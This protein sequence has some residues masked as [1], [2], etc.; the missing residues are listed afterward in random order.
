MQAL[1]T[2]KADDFYISGSSPLGVPFNNLRG[3]SAERARVERIEKGRPGAPCT[4]K[5]LV[6][7]TEFGEAPICTAS[8][9]YQHHKIKELDNLALDNEEYHERL[10]KITEK[11]CLCEGLATAAY[12]KYEILEKKEPTVVAICPGPNTAYFNKVYSLQEMVDHIY[13]RTNIL[14]TTQRPHMFINELNLYVDHLKKYIVENRKEWSDKN[15]KFANRFEEELNKGIAYYED[16]AD[17][18]FTNSADKERFLK[19][20]QFAKANMP[21]EEYA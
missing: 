17:K 4:K 19:Q 18:L 10:A 11:T 3:C 9:V 12:L 14:N 15:T 7:S 21:S 5:Y 16:L 6:M 2:A 13:G 1:A 20:L 8:R